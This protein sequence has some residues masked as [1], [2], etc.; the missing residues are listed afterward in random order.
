MKFAVVVV[1]IVCLLSRSQSCGLNREE[2]NSVN[3]SSSSSSQRQPYSL[4]VDPRAAVAGWVG[5]WYNYL[6]RECSVARRVS[7]YTASLSRSRICNNAADDKA[8][9]GENDVLVAAIEK[10]IR[11]VMGTFEGAGHT[12]DVAVL[13]FLRKSMVNAVKSG[14]FEADLTK[15]IVAGSTNEN[16][17][18]NLHDVR[19]M[20]GLIV[21]SPIK[22]SFQ[23]VRE[24]L[25]NWIKSLEQ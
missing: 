6:T 9:G 14:D 5:G 16:L 25:V 21:G 13:D 20:A 3:D 11:E 15:L 8:K 1:A 10:R 19:R 4:T 17:R 12:V 22:N 7:T 23:S 18:G 24:A 2:S